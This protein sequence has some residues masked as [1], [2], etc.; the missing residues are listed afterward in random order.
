MAQIGLRYPVVAKLS[1]VDGV[2]SY[3]NGMDIEEARN[4]D[5]NITTE[6]S[7]LWGSDRPVE[8]ETIF[9]GGTITFEATR[10]LP[11]KR[12]FL[13]GNKTVSAGIPGKPEI[14]EIVSSEND[15]APYVGFGCYMPV[16]HYGGRKWRA[17]W[18]T[19]VKFREPNIQ[20]QTREEGATQY[21]TP[22]LEGVV[23]RDITGKWKREITVDTEADAKA[24]LNAIAGIGVPADK[25]ALNS[26]ISDA[27]ELDPEDY[28]SASWVEFA[29]ALAHAQAV[30]AAI[31][32]TQAQVDDAL[33]ALTVAEGNLVERS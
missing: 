13:L 11:E 8:S 19:K 21:R 22:T 17:V 12:A 14:T 15:V 6:E 32:P 2:V 30:A 26:A 33:D 18:L 3:D 28:T 29:N 23:E 1:E 10:L 16:A 4:L 24:W 25:T 7:S 9:T 5:V 27:L 31:N 20:G